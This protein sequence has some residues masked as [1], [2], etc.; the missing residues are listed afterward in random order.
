MYNILNFL[1]ILNLIELNFAL[2]R[3]GIP[4]QMVAQR[5]SLHQSPLQQIPM[6]KI[7][8]NMC[9]I[10]IIYKKILSHNFN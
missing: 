2:L 6:F 4:T 3:F 9:G 1:R 8:Q 7:I 10:H 5:R